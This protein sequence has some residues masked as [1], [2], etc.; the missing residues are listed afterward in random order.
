MVQ[1]IRT[2]LVVSLTVMNLISI[3][4]IFMI[5]NF[6]KRGIQYKNDFYIQNNNY[7][8]SYNRTNLF[9]NNGFEEIYHYKNF[10]INYTT[11]YAVVLLLNIICVFFWI[12]LISS[13]CSGEQ[14]CYCEGTCCDGNCNC[15]NCSINNG[16]AGKSA[17]L[18]LLFI[19]LIL[20]IYYSLKCCGKHIARYISLS[21]IAFANLCIFILSLLMLDHERNL[22]YQII[23]FSA[24]SCIANLSS[25]ILPNLPSCE[26]LRFRSRIPSENVSINQ[27]Q[28]PQY[29]NNV[30]MNNNNMNN[31]N[32][33]PI[34]AN[35]IVNPNSYITNGG[36]V[37]NYESKPSTEKNININSNDFGNQ[38]IVDNINDMGDA[39]LPDNENQVKK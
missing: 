28:I 22:I 2:S 1:K 37:V 7:R 39:P 19:C 11:Y 12:F 24:L 15:G 20:V 26:R 14:E 3:L 32:K 30:M 16:E 34:Q 21:I 18:C 13:F 33:A 6:D 36:P 9:I 23:L 8:N 38:I 31:Y 27:N 4:A 35:Y 17:L 10:F 29:N 25:I 5:I